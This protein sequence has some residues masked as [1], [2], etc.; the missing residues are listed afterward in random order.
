MNRAARGN[1]PTADRPIEEPL[2]N[3]DNLENYWAFGQPLA[4]PSVN[5]YHRTPVA[6]IGDE[7]VGCAPAPSKGRSAYEAS[8]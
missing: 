7:N 5:A 2:G 1:R 6:F 4:P 8:I 3:I